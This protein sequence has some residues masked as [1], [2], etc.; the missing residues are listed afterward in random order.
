MFDVW[1]LRLRSPILSISTQRKGARHLR[2]S[3]AWGLLVADIPS[4]ARN[5]ALLVVVAPLSLH[6]R[7]FLLAASDPRR[8]KVT[9]VSHSVLAWSR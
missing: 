8:A 5:A 6:A 1:P 3:A 7:L 2:S 9:V 4:L